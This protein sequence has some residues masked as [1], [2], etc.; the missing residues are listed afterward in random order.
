MAVIGI[1]GFTGAAVLAGVAGIAVFAGFASDSKAV[2]IV[3]SIISSLP[4]LWFGDENDGGGGSIGDAGNLLRVRQDSAAK[5]EFRRFQLYCP[6]DF[7]QPDV[8]ISPFL[9]A[10]YQN[11]GTA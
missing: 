11:G 10:E 7:P 3:E 5:T 2:S 4:V 1:T 8:R 9:F 6:D